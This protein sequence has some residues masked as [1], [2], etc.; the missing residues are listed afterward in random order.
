[1]DKKALITILSIIGVSALGFYLYKKGAF[2][3]KGLPPV[4]AFTNPISQINFKS[5]ADIKAMNTLAV[6][7]NNPTN[8]KWTANSRK[9]P[10]EGQTGE[11]GNF[12]VFSSPA[13]GFRAAARILKNYLARGTNTIASIIKAWA[14]DSDNNDTKSYIAYVS[15][16][17][18]KLETSVITTKD[19]PELLAAMARIESGKEW[20]MGDILKGIA[21]EQKK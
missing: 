17:L 11:N 13:Y 18:N 12:V 9:N 6:K 2:K 1:M 3:V 16:R 20:L 14:P 8:I 10:W 19:F 7:N 15:K 5:G 4:N 21:L